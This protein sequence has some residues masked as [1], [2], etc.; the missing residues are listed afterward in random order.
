[1]SKR[2]DDIKYRLDDMLH[3]GKGSL[4]QEELGEFHD[5]AR[6]MREMPM[7]D[8]PYL[9]QNTQYEPHEIE[10]SRQPPLAT[11]RVSEGTRRRVKKKAKKKEQKKRKGSGEWRD[12][13]NKAQGFAN[14]AADVSEHMNSQMF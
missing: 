4:S 12:I 5:L 6:E 8:R 11:Y 3:R 7:E 13:R 14:W 10:A 9:P 1:M 2:Y